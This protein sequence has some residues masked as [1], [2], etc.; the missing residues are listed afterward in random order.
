MLADGQLHV[1]ALELELTLLRPHQARHHAQQRGF[2]C[3]IGAGHHECFARLDGKGERTKD[4]AA[5]SDA[6]EI[7]RS[8]PHQAM[9][10]DVSPGGHPFAL[11]HPALAP[12]LAGTGVGINP[13]SM[14]MS[15]VSVDFLEWC[16][17]RPYKP[18]SCA[19]YQ[20]ALD[21][22]PVTRKRFR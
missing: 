12:P 4:L 11:K 13:D 1:A 20:P 19:A 8:E 7:G 6:G 14:R 16:K 3:P 18:S 17:K 15:L 10:P 5:P 22:R 2:A 21:S 9:A